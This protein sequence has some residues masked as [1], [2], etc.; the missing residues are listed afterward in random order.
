M[1]RARVAAAEPIE[2]GNPSPASQSA[3]GAERGWRVWLR[4]VGGGGA[5]ADGH[6]CGPMGGGGRAGLAAT[7]RS[8]SC[9][10]ER[11]GADCDWQEC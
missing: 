2:N 11:G 4:P 5:T 8:V 9:A 7:C 10:G 1:P 3:G 6:R